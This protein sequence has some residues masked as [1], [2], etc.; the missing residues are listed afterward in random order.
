MQTDVLLVHIG[1]V[2]TPPGPGPRKGTHQGEL[3]R[4]VDAAIALREGQ[5]V[6]VGP[7]QEWSGTA[8]VEVDLGGRAVVPGLVDPHTHAVWAGDRLNDFEARAQGV[9]Y[10]QILAAGGGIYQT[11]RHTSEADEETLVRLARPRLERLLRSGATTVEVKSGYGLSPDA[12]LKMLRAI[13]RLQEAIPITVV[14]TLLIHVP[15]FEDR[16][17][18]VEEVIAS[19]IPAVAR[20]N[21]ARAVD[22]F[23]EKE[24]FTVS[25]AE[26]I[27]RAAQA[28]GLNVKLHADQFHVLGGVELGVRLA[29]LSVDHLE[30]SGEAQWRALAQ[31]DTIATVLPGVTLHLGSPAAS[32]RALVDAGAAVA[33]ATDV[34]PGSSPLFSVSLAL[35][36]AVRLNG[37]TPAEALTAGTAN[38]AA[39]LALFD[40]GYIDVGARADLIVLES[41]DWRELV[42][43][44][45]ADD[46]IAQVYVAG[47][48]VWERA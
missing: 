3:R 23:V 42:Y 40:R 16:E 7:R 24:A 32:G 5:I 30:A 35:A 29:A 44:V 11:I 15:P 22:V 48:V 13:A 27:L 38:A 41:A 36:L 14:P 20:E 8:R 45:G 9:S 6:W 25:E 21:L 12:E 33:V 2:V 10:E 17:G 46:L 1:E 18:Y 47:Q 26:R 4:I 37:L 31:S 43:A 28:H 39:A 19:L 34:N